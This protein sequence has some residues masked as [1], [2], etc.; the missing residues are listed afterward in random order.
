ML[1][2]ACTVLATLVMLVVLVVLE[3]LVM[4]MKTPT[5]VFV[6][7]V[8]PGRHQRRLQTTMKTTK[9]SAAVGR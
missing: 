7:R 3:V 2:W 1:W 9:D 8:Q 4:M 6:G 5:V